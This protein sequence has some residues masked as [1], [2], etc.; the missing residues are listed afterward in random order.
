MNNWLN[1][2][3]KLTVGTLTIFA[4]MQAGADTRTSAGYSLEAA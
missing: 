1:S 4:A 2:G 3:W